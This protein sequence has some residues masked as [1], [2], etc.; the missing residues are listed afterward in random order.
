[1]YGGKFCVSKCIGL[2]LFLEGN[3]PFFFAS[4][5]IEGDFQIQATPPLP[6]GGGGSLCLEVR[7]NGGFFALGV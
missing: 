1:M 5:C 2:T 6:P 7:L 4:L 3:L